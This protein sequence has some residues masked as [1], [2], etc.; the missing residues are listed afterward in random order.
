MTR[1]QLAHAYDRLV[2]VRVD[3]S[4]TA[5]GRNPNEVE[6]DSFDRISDDVVDGA[7]CAECACSA[8]IIIDFVR[9][10]QRRLA[11]GFKGMT[12]NDFKRVLMDRLAEYEAGGYVVPRV[13]EASYDPTTGRINA[14][15]EFDLEPVVIR[16]VK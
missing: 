7:V 15:I 2:H 9:E 4:Q 16:Q 6:C 11:E 14:V 8:P 5:C 12:P 10:L 13:G 3:C 1:A